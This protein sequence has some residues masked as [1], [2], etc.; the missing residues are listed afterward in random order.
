VIPKAVSAAVVLSLVLMTLP[1]PYSE[2]ATVTIEEGGRWTKPLDLATAAHVTLIVRGDEGFD[3]TI[4]PREGAVSPQLLRVLGTTV[5]HETLELTGNT[6][7]LTVTNDNQA[8]LVIDYQVHV[9]YLLFGNLTAKNL[10]VVVLVF[11][12]I[13][14]AAVLH[15]RR[16]RGR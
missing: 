3:L 12:L 2:K 11:S 15:R 4:S 16:S 8:P 7:Y 13:V 9:D 6:Y 1:L 5:Y 10:L 14:L